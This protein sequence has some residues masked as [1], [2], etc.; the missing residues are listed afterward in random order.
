[1]NVCVN[2]L[3]N[4]CLSFESGDSSPALVDDSLATGC[5]TFSLWFK[6]NSSAKC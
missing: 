4:F 3:M 1:M 5:A 2:F 6:F